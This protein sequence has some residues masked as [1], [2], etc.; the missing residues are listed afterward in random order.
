MKHFRIVLILVLFLFSGSTFDLSAQDK[1]KEKKLEKVVFG[2]SMHCDN[3]KKKIEKNISWEKGVKDLR[4]DLEEKTVTLLFDPKK[5]SA[6]TLKIA[7]EKL[8]F[9]CEFSPPEKKKE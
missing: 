9:T 3:C 8:D 6:Q 5:T 7:I 1:T 4:I 2:V